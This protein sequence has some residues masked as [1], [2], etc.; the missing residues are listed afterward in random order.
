MKLYMVA[1]FVLWAGSA[2]CQQQHLQGTYVINYG[3]SEESASKQIEI[4]YESPTKTYFYLEANNGAPGYHSGS[5]YGRLT[6][7]RSTGNMEYVPAN[8]DDDCKLEFKKNGN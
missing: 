8:A 4:Y 5:L 2:F 7:N 3:K 6:F 1:V